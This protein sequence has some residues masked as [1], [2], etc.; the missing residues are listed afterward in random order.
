M[1]PRPPSA[2]VLLGAQRFEPTLDRAVF[3]VG[4]MQ[5]Q[6]DYLGAAPQLP[7]FGDG[8]Q[9]MDLMAE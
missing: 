7:L 8:I 2:V 6:K 4:A 3:S 1:S 9:L 5:R